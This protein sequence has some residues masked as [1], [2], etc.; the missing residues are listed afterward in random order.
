MYFFSLHYYR[1]SFE[2][3]VDEYIPVR[4]RSGYAINIGARDGKD[5]DPTFP[6]FAQYVDQRLPGVRALFTMLSV[7]PRA[8]SEF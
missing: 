4:L 6:L 5:H 7:P 3:F 2:K 1:P 8:P